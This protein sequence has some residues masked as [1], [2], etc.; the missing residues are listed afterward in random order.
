[1]SSKHFAILGTLFFLLTFS[2][3]TSDPGS[4]YYDD[5]TIYSESNKT[6]LSEV[7]LFLKPYFV[8][9]GEKV[10]VVSNSV[11]NITL[12]I[13]EK[14]WKSPNSFEVDTIH[15][16]HKETIS[17]YRITSEN[18]C[19]PASINI[20]DYPKT[21][22]TAGQYAD[23]LTDH[24]YL[25]PGTYIFQLVSFDIKDASGNLKT[26]YTPT[27]FLALEVKENY[28]SINLGEFEI[29]IK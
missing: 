11:E 20:V 2:S 28:A 22:E 18:L 15:L 12:K 1:M 10:Y 23:I 14:T 7:I 21:L 24:I 17:E 29:E 8:H 9:E 5:P 4:Y 6:L 3:C 13:N 16:K 25:K 26:I 19:Y 27:L